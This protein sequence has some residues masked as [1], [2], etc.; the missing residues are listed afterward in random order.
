[1]TKEERI[2]LAENPNT[3]VDILDQLSRDEDWEVRQEVAK[4]P[5]T[6]VETFDR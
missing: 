6:S 1:M 4:N 3:P 2:E 5:N